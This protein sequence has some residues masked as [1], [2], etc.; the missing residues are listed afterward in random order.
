M[1]ILILIQIS[2]GT[3]TA[4]SGG[5]GVLLQHPE[6]RNKSKIMGITIIGLTIAKPKHGIFLVRFD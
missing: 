3:P 5:S 1:I 6:R 2:I 4:I